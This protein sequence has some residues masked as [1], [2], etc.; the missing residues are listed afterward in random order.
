[1]AQK[2]YSTYVQEGSEILLHVLSEFIGDRMKKAYG[3][4]WWNEIL[5]TF[6]DAQPPLPKAGTDEELLDSLD[7]ARCIKIIKWKWKDAFSDYFGTDSRKQQTYAHELLDIRNS[8]AH[9]GRKDIEQE[10][11]ERA[12]D[13]MYRFCKYINVKEAEKI[14]DLYKEVRNGGLSNYIIDGPTSIDVPSNIDHAVI[15]P[16]DVSNL[17]KLIGTDIVMKTTLTKKLT[18]GGKEQAFPVFKVKLEYLYYNDQ[19][20]RVGTWISRYC[21]E[22]GNNSLSSLERDKYNDVIEE[23]VYESNPDAIKKTQKNIQ[24]YGQREPGV[25]LFDGR[26]I[27]GNRRY[28][29]LRRLNREDADIQ[30][31][32][33]VLIDSDIDVYCRIKM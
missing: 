1:M 5:N 12:L 16:R 18:L 23:F 6:Y 30:Y 27:D 7:F 32:E 24:R 8:R 14:K 11:A 33:T 13:T 9:T 22:N 31:F 28:T 4:N 10:D 26:I 2:L 21:S 17:N 19:N 15:A 20:D 3:K 25:T 29:C